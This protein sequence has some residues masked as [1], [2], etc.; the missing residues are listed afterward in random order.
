LVSFLVADLDLDLDWVFFLGF[1]S[2]LVAAL[3]DLE[4]NPSSLRNC[5][6]SEAVTCMVLSLLG[7]TTFGL[8]EAFVVEAFLVERFGES[9]RASNALSEGTR[10]LLPA[11]TRVV[12]WS[13]VME[14]LVF[15]SLV[16]VPLKKRKNPRKTPNPNPDPNLL[17]KKK[18]K[19]PL[20]KAFQKIPQKRLKKN[21]MIRMSKAIRRKL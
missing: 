4:E 21:P 7:G 15:F 14:F 5:L 6:P 3:L 20:L 12:G 9:T 11:T 13:L 8:G 10:F 2:S 18:P 16:V 19:H 17:P 1:F